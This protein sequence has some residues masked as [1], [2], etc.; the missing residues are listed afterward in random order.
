MGKVFIKIKNNMVHSV[1][2]YSTDVE[3]DDEGDKT[4]M[5]FKDQEQIY[6]KRKNVHPVRYSIVEMD[7]QEE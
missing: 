4:I 3:I 1:N 5:K 7:T 6:E 2:G